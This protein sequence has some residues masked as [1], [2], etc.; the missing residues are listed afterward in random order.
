MQP[1][2]MRTDSGWFPALYVL[3]NFIHPQT[4][5]C[6]F[7]FTYTHIYIEREKK[8]QR[9]TVEKGQFHVAHQTQGLPISLLLWAAHIVTRAS[10]CSRPH[11]K[12]L[13]HDA[14]DSTPFLVWV[15]WGGAL[16]ELLDHVGHWGSVLFTAW[17]AN[18][19]CLYDSRVIL[20]SEH[21]PS[22]CK[23]TVCVH[24][25]SRKCGF[26]RIAHKA[27]AWSIGFYYL[28]LLPLIG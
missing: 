10:S 17:A 1:K 21:R 11:Q 13:S 7:L 15:V 14:R 4:W 20:Y 19:D 2:L 22:L 25:C 23:T 16:Y 18:L 6:W 5:I 28:N 9:E 12:D 26:L 27:G 8:K 3:G 24:I